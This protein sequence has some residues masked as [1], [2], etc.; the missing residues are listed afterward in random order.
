[1]RKERIREWMGRKKRKSLS[2]RG[3]LEEE[4]LARLITSGSK[5]PANH[6]YNTQAILLKEKAIQL[7]P[8]FH[9]RLTFM[10]STQ[11]Y[12]SEYNVYLSADAILPCYHLNHAGLII[13]SPRTNILPTKTYISTYSTAQI[14]QISSFMPAM[15]HTGLTFCLTNDFIFTRTVG[16]PVAT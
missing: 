6:F 8:T 5:F 16:Q 7:R 11:F 2:Q 10:S 13:I 9:L 3:W 15:T 14:L 4:S 1:M 12:H